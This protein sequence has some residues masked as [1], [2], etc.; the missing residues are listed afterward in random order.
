[1]KRGRSE[2]AS[3]EDSLEAVPSGCGTLVARLYQS[4]RSEGKSQQAFVAL[5]N[6][7]GYRLPK[8]TLGR[9]SA[10]VAAHGTALPGGS[11][12]G[13]SARLS[14]E[15]KRIVCGFVFDRQMT[16]AKTTLRDVRDFCRD[17]FDTSI[18][19]ATASR[20]MAELGLSSRKMQTKTAGYAVDADG[21]IEMAYSWLLKHHHAFYA[22]NLW[23]ID[24]YFT[25]HRL[26]THHSFVVSGG[27]PANFS[28]GICSYTA[29]GLTL[30]CGDGRY[31]KSVLYTS[32]PI[33]NRARAP[34]P[35]RT[36]LWDEIDELCA[37]YGVKADR[38]V[39]VPPPAN[40]AT[41]HIVPAS[42]AIVEDFISRCK[43]EE[44]AIVLSDGGAEFAN[45]EAL[46][47]AQHITYPAPVHQY[48]S[49]NDNRLHGAAKQA[50]GAAGIDFKNDA[51]ALV[52]LL[53]FMDE[54]MAGVETWF[55]TNLQVDSLSV[56]Q[57]KV[58]ALI[59]GN[60]HVDN[61][62]YIECRREYRFV[63][64][65]D[66]RG[67]YKDRLADGLDGRYWD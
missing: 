26:D 40:K 59:R 46:G 2:E 62:F 6:N 67:E 12:R 43:L 45:L 30:I 29:F 27:P 63:C 9:W 42:A 57:E 58:A 35:R 34:T 28:G 19:D 64:G 25:G 53:H 51:M 47:F 49:P 50:W 39:Y 65:L 32:N 60:K 48:L 41:K 31:Y 44:G 11:P 55:Q 38:I 33:F 5:F 56:S 4:W 37:H 8:A 13:R 18:S 10:G 36:A 7:A 16:N 20:L 52:S 3:E 61:G 1:M 17:H 15:Q 21:A 24:G 23:S 66:P 22:S 54:A 14:D